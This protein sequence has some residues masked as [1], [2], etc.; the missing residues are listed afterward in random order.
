MEQFILLDYGTLRIVWWALLGFLL[1]AFA[2]MDGATMGVALMLPFVA[3]TDA[4]RRS[5]Y[6]VIGPVWEGSQVW[7]ILAGGVVFAAW[8]LLY[9]MSFS[10]FYLAMLLLLVAL[11][12]R[13]VAINYRSKRTDKAWRDRWDVLWTLT[14]FIS[15]LVFGVAVGNVL[16]GVP[17]TFDP[18]SLRPIYEGGFFGLFTLFPLFCGLISVLMTAAH[19]AAWL[20][21]KADGPIVPRAARVGRIA[22][23][24]SGLLFALG[25]LWVSKGID[26]YSISSAVQPAL[27][28]NPLSKTVVVSAGAL[29][30]NFAQ[31]PM[32]WI[33]PVLGVGGAFLALVLFFFRGTLLTSLATATS[34]A[35]IVL[36]FGFA[37]FPFLL[38][39]SS[40]PD[41]SLTVW[42]ASASHFSLWVMLICTVIFMPMIILYTAWVYRVVRGKVLIEVSEDAAS[43][44]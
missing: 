2:V 42:D 15:S 5:L 9:A 31:W 41:A 18:D 1:V 7:L 33:A 44:H 34:I 14:G 35:G 36:T 25:G 11:I 26:G 19:G 22:V 40:N 37:L 24:L 12:V 13:P 4:E 29:M 39:S 23:L 17:F 28:S 8:P 32:M 10:G 6:N 27:A 20:T 43:H 16:I 30:G 3:H 38:P 21:W